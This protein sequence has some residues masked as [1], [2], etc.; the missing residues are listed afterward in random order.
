MTEH[1]HEITEMVRRPEIHGAHWHRVVCACGW[2]GTY[3]SQYRCRVMH[4]KHRAQV[5]A[6]A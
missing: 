2:S 4:D 6:R 5:K 1:E 3:V